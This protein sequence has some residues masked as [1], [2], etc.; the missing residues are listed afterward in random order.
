MRLLRRGRET[1][2]RGR[3][4]GRRGGQAIKKKKG[5]GES[6]PPW[7][8]DVEAR[9]GPE[10]TRSRQRRSPFR[11]TNMLAGSYVVASKKTTS[12]RERIPRRDAHANH[13]RV[14]ANRARGRLAESCAQAVGVVVRA[15]VARR[16]GGG[17][18]RGRGGGG[19]AT[20]GLV[21]KQA[22]FLSWPEMRHA[23]AA[24]RGGTDTRRLVGQLA[25]WL[26]RRRGAARRSVSKQASK[27]AE[28]KQE[29][30]TGGRN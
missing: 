1:R 18:R 7:R 28:Q 25:G 27:Q 21:D 16:R 23:A 8:P 15:G 6:S 20:G 4:R 30:A 14:V 10:R 19:D 2:V 29:K 13:C 5:G 11:K 3:S 9:E 12:D 24:A 22:L 26:A 17:G